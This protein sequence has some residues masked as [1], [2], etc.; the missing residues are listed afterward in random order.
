M[1]QSF[2]FTGC[3]ADRDFQP[4]KIIINNITDA[5]KK[6]Y[7]IILV[8]TKSF[9][10]SKWCTH[11]MEYAIIRHIG[12]EECVIPLLLEP[13]EEA[14]YPDCLQ[15]I[16]YPDYTNERNQMQEIRKLKKALLVGGH[17]E[18]KLNER[19]QSS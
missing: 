14:E 17:K 7:K 15:R 5:I 12:I 10:Q 9:V 3:I 8:L 18:S 2:L 11:E 19:T 6:S 16:T 1:N 4:G 13:L